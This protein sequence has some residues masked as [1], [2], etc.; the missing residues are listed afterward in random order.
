MWLHELTNPIVLSDPMQTILRSTGSLIDPYLKSNSLILLYI[1][2][3]QHT[4]YP[5]NLLFVRDIFALQ[6]PGIF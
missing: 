6:S 1:R 5:L 3:P 2:V 4:V